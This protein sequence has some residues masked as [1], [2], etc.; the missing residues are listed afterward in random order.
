MA[1]LFGF[2][3]K[4]KR[5]LEPLPA[6]TKPDIM[7]GSLEVAAGGV[8][9]TVVD[10]DGTVRSEAELIDKYRQM[11]EHPEVDSAIDDIVNESITIDQKKDIV[12]L[13]MEDLQLQ[14]NIKK[15]IIDEFNTILQL[16]EFNSYAYDIFRRWYVDGRLYYELVIDPNNPKGGIQ[17]LRYIDPRKIRK[18]K[19]T[20]RKRDPRTKAEL[21]VPSAE[22]YIY[23]EKGFTKA[24]QNQTGNY[25]AA[26]Q[27]IKIAKD[28]IVHIVSGLMSAKGDMVLGHL[29]KA[30][31]PLNQLRSMEDSL[32]I[33]RISRAPE[34]R[35]FYIDVGNLPKMKAEQYVKDIMTRFKNRLVY[36]S[37]TGELR[38]DRKFMT[39]L[40]D[41]WLP[42]REGGKGTEISVLPGGQNL[43]QMDDVTYF[44]KKLY[45]SLNV[46]ITR[47]EANNLYGTG[48]ATEVTRD[49]VKF[50]KFIDRLHTRFS[51]LFL[52]LL[53][54]QLILKRIITP[55]DWKSISDGI[56]IIYA[57]DNFF[58]EQKNAQIMLARMELFNSV[59]PVVGKYMSHENV[60]R[61][62]LQQT[63]GDIKV[64][65]AQ[66]LQELENPIYNPPPPPDAEV[67]AAASAA[68]PGKP[69]Q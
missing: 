37:A 41:F 60:R 28:S 19:E 58:Q 15:L 8:Y 21:P 67:A 68:Q 35:V 54:R 29:H 50:S 62:I 20:K 22:Y 3:F 65:D 59:A 1:E 14:D 33:Y 36:D 44:Q 25:S 10:L 64:N 39:M 43:G 42:R 16:L 55:D 24:L 18:I 38:D 27:G 46:P 2:E 4:R 13:D 56:Q 7:D 61:N 40:E 9:G 6:I 69:A 51:L 12:S 32:V 5:D 49:E 30:I 52:K 45:E 23:N 48:R 11:S 57:R 26:T 63:D 53:E 47:M 66:I 31:K 34:R 17:E